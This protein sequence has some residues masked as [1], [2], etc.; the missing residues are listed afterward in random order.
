MCADYM[1][2]AYIGT[3]FDGTAVEKVSI[4]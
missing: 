1:R 2:D 3:R 4:G